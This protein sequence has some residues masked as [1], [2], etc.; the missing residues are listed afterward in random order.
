SESERAGVT[1]ESAPLEE[2]PAPSGEE[3]TPETGPALERAF[4]VEELA[5]GPKTARA[6]DAGPYAPELPDAPLA[7]EYTSG[8]GRPLPS[9]PS[10]PSGGLGPQPAASA[11]QLEV[12]ELPETESTP[13]AGGA[14]APACDVERNEELALAAVEAESRE[15]R[16][17]SDVD[18]GP[19]G[20][21]PAPPFREGATEDPSEADAKEELAAPTPPLPGGESFTDSPEASAG[22]AT[23]EV[24]VFGPDSEDLIGSPPFQPRPLS[25]EESEPHGH[26]SLEWIDSEPPLAPT[27][28]ALPT[29]WEGIPADEAESELAEA[30]ESEEDGWSVELEEVSAAAREHLLGR[31]PVADPAPFELQ[32]AA[33]S[34]ADEELGDPYAIHL[35]RAVDLRRRGDFEDAIR[36]LELATQS[37]ACFEEAYRLLQ[38]CR[39]NLT[40]AAQEEPAAAVQ[41]EPAAAVQEEPAAAVQEEPAPAPDRADLPHAQ[42]AGETGGEAGGRDP[43]SAEVFEEWLEE[44]SFTVLERTLQEL[45]RRGELDRARQIVERLIQLEASDPSLHQKRIEYATAGGDEDGLAQAFLELG[46]ALEVE[47]RLA[48]ARAAYFR[49]LEYDP[50][51][52]AARRAIELVED[53]AADLAE[54]ERALQERTVQVYGPPAP[55]PDGSPPRA[56]EEVGE[57][58]AG[59]IPDEWER[60]D[61]EFMPSGEFPAGA[62]S[63]G[64]TPYDRREVGREGMVDFDVILAELKEQLAEGAADEPDGSSR[65]EVGERLRDMGLLDDAIR[66]LQAAVRSPDAPPRAFELLGE[67]FIEKGQ[68]RVAARLLREALER[69]S[70]Q[71]ERKLLGVLY[72]LGVAFQTVDDTSKALECYERIFSV[73]IDYRDVRERIEACVA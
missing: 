46:E 1:S 57:P 45:E 66:E 4:P 7:A 42:P 33:E 29:S 27:G 6:A 15:L 23:P 59:A 51:S 56:T 69:L 30:G 68:A 50:D 14:P 37:P 34:P 21:V 70:G 16:H 65:T 26:R 71:E 19:S 8:R 5:S 43:F 72:Q 22:L 35:A 62:D 28:R 63:I 52:D 9:E 67:A 55:A 64:V 49:A 25:P 39:R 41:E 44:S 40:A 36:E 12:G 20:F 53:R 17:V 31:D 73:D 61:V 2:E 38:E 54:Q 18:E 47:G 10:D 11:P 13:S 24:Q 58:P 32:E 60:A 3:V 48:E